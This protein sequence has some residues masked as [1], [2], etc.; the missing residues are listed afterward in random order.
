V[1]SKLKATLHKVEACTHETMVEAIGRALGTV[2]RR[3]ALGWFERCGYR[4]V[5]HSL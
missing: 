3:D 2:S 4:I 1:F 5:D